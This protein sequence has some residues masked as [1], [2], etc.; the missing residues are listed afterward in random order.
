MN[1][2]S[3]QN[4]SNISPSGIRRQPQHQEKLT[5]QFKTVLKHFVLSSIS[6]NLKSTEK[7]C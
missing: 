3:V 1:L 6:K 4:S 7:H 2:A 5:A